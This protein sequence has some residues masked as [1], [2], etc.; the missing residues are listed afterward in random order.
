LI[1]GLRASFAD[2]AWMSTSNSIQRKNARPERSPLGYA[3]FFRFARNSRFPAIRADLLEET[4]VPEC[5]GS[6]QVPAFADF[7][8]G[9]ACSAG[10]NRAK[11]SCKGPLPCDSLSALAENDF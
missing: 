7:P 9:K 11:A 8:R 1:I 5:N 3:R 10:D 6:G 2:R 4:A